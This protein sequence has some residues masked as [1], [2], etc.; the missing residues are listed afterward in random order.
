MCHI[1]TKDKL[2]VFCIALSIVPIQYATKRNPVPYLYSS[3]IFDIKGPRYCALR[4]EE[5]QL[6]TTS[7]I[8]GLQMQW[9]G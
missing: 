4:V 8:V 7:S 1:T 9:V 6:F 2:L 3:S 5:V